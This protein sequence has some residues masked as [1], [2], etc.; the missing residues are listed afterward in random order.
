MYSCLNNK[1]SA[2]SAFVKL[3]KVFDTIDYQIL[4]ENCINTGYEDF[5]YSC[6]FIDYLKN[7]FIFAYERFDLKFHEIIK[8]FFDK[9]YFCFDWT[10]IFCKLS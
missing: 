5:H 1:E 4:F 9:N 8:G 6:F 3:C 7:W 10:E 2:L